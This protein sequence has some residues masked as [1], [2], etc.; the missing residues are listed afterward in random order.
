MT[1]TFGIKRGLLTK[2]KITLLAVA[3]LTLTACSSVNL[4]QKY[5]D[6]SYVEGDT[7]R[8]INPVP[9][10][11]PF[12]YMRMRMRTDPVP[13]PEFVPLQENILIPPERS[14]SL[15]IQSVGHATFLIQLAGINILTDPIFAQRASPISWA[16][17]KVTPALTV[18]S[19]RRLTCC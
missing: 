4:E 15:R 5:P 19:C 1:F 3:A 16:G 11:G 12:A 18:G 7:F 9:E 2:A 10:Q 6:L 8:N 13:W 17:P 14:E